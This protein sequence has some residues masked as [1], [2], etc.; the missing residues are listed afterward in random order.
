MSNNFTIIRSIYV[1]GYVCENACVKLS[2]RFISHCDLAELQHFRNALKTYSPFSTIRMPKTWGDL[3]QICLSLIFSKHHTSQIVGHFFPYFFQYYLW[4]CDELCVNNNIHSWFISALAYIFQVVEPMESVMHRIRK[5]NKKNDLCEYHEWKKR[6]FICLIP[7]INVDFFLFLLFIRSAVRKEQ[8]S[9]SSSFN[10]CDLSTRDGRS[11]K[12]YS[13]KICRKWFVR[14]RILL[15]YHQN[16][17][18]IEL[19]F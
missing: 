3:R 15:W 9:V 4:F 10:V 8:V 5:N 1:F 18:N 7:C 2:I 14:C 6:R 19:D 16:E 17:S 11:H 13:S 12:F